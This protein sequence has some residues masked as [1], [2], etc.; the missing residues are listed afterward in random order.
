[1]RDLWDSNDFP[2]SLGLK[3]T[4]GFAPNMQMAIIPTRPPVPPWIIR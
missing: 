4:A 2:E 3:H 1:M